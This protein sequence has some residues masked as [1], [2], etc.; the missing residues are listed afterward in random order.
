MAS[1]VAICLEGV[2]RQHNQD[3]IIGQGALLYHS[4]KAASRIAIL[5]D[6]DSRNA[7]F[8][9]KLNGFTEHIQVLTADDVARDVA[10]VRLRQVM[11]LVSEGGMLSC[12]L[13]P[14]P[15]V[16]AALLAHG[17]PVFVPLFPS[18]TKPSFRPDYDGAVTPWS[19]LTNELDRQRELRAKDDRT[20][21]DAL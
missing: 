4:L 9:L 14:D 6:K 13:E 12:V 5:L 3:G 15:E 10:E 18:Y 17:Y 8:W 11:R 19:A 21:Q 1:T 2:L 7:D 20:E 16:G